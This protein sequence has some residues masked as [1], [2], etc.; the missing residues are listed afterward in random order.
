MNTSIRMI[1]FTGVYD[2]LGDTPELKQMYFLYDTQIKATFEEMQY[3]ED[4]DETGEEEVTRRCVE[5]YS[6][7]DD[8]VD[9]ENRMLTPRDDCDW[10]ILKIPVLI[11]NET[12]EVLPIKR[13]RGRL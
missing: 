11:N 2:S 13:K 9:R 5:Y 10:V 6:T 7:Y 1:Q 8:Y 3:D 12:N 4:G